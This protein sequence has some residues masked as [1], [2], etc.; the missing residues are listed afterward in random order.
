MNIK[1]LNEAIGRALNEI[2]D[3]PVNAVADKRKDA[4]EKNRAEFIIFINP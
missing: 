1:E 3:A 4:F 2:S